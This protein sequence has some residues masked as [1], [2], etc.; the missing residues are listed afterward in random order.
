M[1]FTMELLN[2][3]E[4]LKVHEGSLRVLSSTG[5]K[6]ESKKMLTGLQKAGAKVDMS[7]KTVL[8]PETLIQTALE[9]NKALL[10]KGKKMHLVNGVTSEIGIGEGIQAKMS[11]GCE[12]YL[13]WDTQSIKPASAAELLEYVRLGELLPD[14]NFVGN[15]IVIKEDLSGKKL[16]ERMRRVKTAELIA[17]NTRKVGSMEVWDEREIDLFVE[18]G[19]IIKGSREAYFDDPCLVTAKETISPLFLDE[20]SGDILLALAE[21]GLPCTIIPMPITGISAPVS[22]LGSVIVGNAEILGVL[23]A[24]F[25]VYPEAVVGGGTISG[26]MDMRTATASFSAPEAILQD[27]AIAEVHERLYGFNYLVGTGYTESKYPSSTTLAE[28]LAKFMVTFLSKRYTYP[29]G[30]LYGGSVFSAEQALVDIELC[31]YIHGHFQSS[32][33]FSSL[34][35]T[36]EVIREIGIRG[37]AINHSHTL[38]NFRQNWMSNIMDRSGFTGLEDSRIKDIYHLAHEQ[39]VKLMSGGS[40]W[41]IEPEKARAIEVVVRKADSLLH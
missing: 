23:T 1:T 26:I 33:D 28:K 11:G 22:K 36:I 21:R 8:F 7:A 10:R 40:Y 35:D 39:R 25:S 31:R 24:I 16:E 41:E 17:K 29:V 6:I 12:K 9:N 2:N 15:P 3:E 20:N 27:L 14:V 37:Q 30:L 38:D 18:M 19:I 13:D 32:F 4:L 34:P 5:M